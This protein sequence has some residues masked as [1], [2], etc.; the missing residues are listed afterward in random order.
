MIRDDLLALS[1]EHLVLLANK[2]LVKRA[3]GELEAGRGMTIET[4][5][6]GTVLARSPD[7]ASTRLPPAT[8]LKQAFCSCGSSSVC[9]HRLGLV[10]AYQKLHDKRTEAQAWDPGELTD[11]TLAVLGEPILKRATGALKGSMLV[12]TIPG[13]TPTAQLPSATVQFLV[14]KQLA[15][16]RC[17]CLRE[18]GCE[19]VV[20]AIWAFRAA[21]Q[22]GIVEIGTAPKA[23]SGR[24]AEDVLVH[25]DDVLSEVVKRGIAGLDS[26]QCIAQSRARMEHAGLLW[27]ADALED[28]ERQKDYYDR[29]STLYSS[30]TC[31]NLVSELAARLRAAR[32]GGHLPAAWVL[33]S[34]EAKET[35]LD[36]V[37]LVALG[38]RIDAD[39]PR[40]IAEVYLAEPDS[41]RVLWLRKTWEVT[42]EQSE[43][44]QTGTGPDL[45]KRYASG[46]LSLEALAKGELLLRGAARRA[47][48]ELD[49]R[50]ARSNKSSLLPQSAAWET[51]PEPLLIRDLSSY[52]AQLRTLPPHFLRPRTLGDAIKVVA[53]GHHR[54]GGYLSATQELVHIAHDLAG[55]PLTLRVPYRA[56]C[57]G[58]LSAVARSIDEGLRFVAGPLSHSAH[59]WQMHPMSVLAQRLR[60]PDLEPQDG[61]LQSQATV[62]TASDPLPDALRHLSEIVE[63]SIHSGFINTLAHFGESTVKR[64]EH[65]GLVRL[66]NLIGKANT[67]TH[68]FLDLAIATTLACER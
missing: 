13:V 9:R 55:N 26:S 11:E 53:I 21:P 47:N 56:I 17:D 50:G 25:V 18:H 45:G 52:E 33:G 65:V 10:L 7:G 19:H 28:L 62:S 16:A 1:L 39:G 60:V 44:R 8:S 24:Y 48:G 58:A 42:Q 22:G 43:K 14:P 35:L 29:Q 12:T 67:G 6:D 37:R 49:L 4:Q 31:A 63:R 68:A 34:D 46:R 54:G 15:F 20:L 36:Q 32:G 66:A 2:G 3:Q 5:T 57:P 41:K 30:Q 64:L 61:M 27:L 51:L 40:R 38:T 23:T 59:G